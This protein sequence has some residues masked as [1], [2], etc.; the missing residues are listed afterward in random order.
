MKVLITGSDGFIG[1]NL[2]LFLTG[3]NDVEVVRY[4]RQ[5]NVAQLPD[6][7]RGVDFVFH[8]AGVNRPKALGD[9]TI[10][11]RDLTQALCSAARDLA[12]AGGKKI[13]LLV[14]SSIQ[15]G[16]D[17]PYGLSKRAAEEAA[18]AL[19]QSHG[20]PV[21]VFRLPNVFGKW[22]RPNYNSAIATF[23]HNIARGLPIEIQAP[24]APISLIYIDDLI[25]RFIQLMDGA[26]TAEDANGYETVASQYSTTVGEVAALI[27]RFKSSRETLTTETVGAGFVR[28]LYSTY[29]SY[30]PTESFTYPVPQHIDQRGAF[31]EML[32]TRDSGQFSYFSAHP[33]VTRGG[34][35]HHSKT[36]KFLVIKGRARFQFRHMHTGDAYEL[37]TSGDKAEIVETPPGWAHDITNIGE[38]EMI[39]ILWANEVFDRSHPDTYTYPL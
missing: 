12:E 32:K 9:F 27:Y 13:P 19:K 16:G 36:E 20:V 28:A 2:L 34:H 1:K 4:S 6:M 30:L 11:N 31:V 23:C 7:M 26:A 38:E 22:G 18:F 21:H 35:Y 39:V 24:D 25:E 10:G 8:L 37:L 5:N 14:T 17:T 15:A 33:G 3:R 29:I